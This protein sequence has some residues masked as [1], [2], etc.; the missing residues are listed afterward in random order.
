MCGEAAAGVGQG[1]G[2]KPRRGARKRFFFLDGERE[3]SR[4]RV[5]GLGPGVRVHVRNTYVAS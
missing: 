3:R 1:G 4:Q 2:R 5:P